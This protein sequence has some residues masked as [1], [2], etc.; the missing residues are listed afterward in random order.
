MR[1]AV[2]AAIDADKPHPV[3]CPN[4]EH[5]FQAKVPDHTARLKAV[6]LALSQGFG[7]APEQAKQPEQ[8]KAGPTESPLRRFSGEE[9]K[10]LIAGLRRHRIAE[11]PPRYADAASRAYR[12]Y[13]IG[14]GYGSVPTENTNTN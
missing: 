2:F 3:R 5:K 13:L 9:L 4:C 11:E 1:E 12:K 8:A 7:R 14:L 10:E 6:D